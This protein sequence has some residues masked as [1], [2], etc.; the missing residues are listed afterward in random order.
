MEL[1]DIV[2]QLAATERMRITEAEGP[3]EC[4]RVAVA[5]SPP[6]AD[7]TRIGYE[8]EPPVAVAEGPVRRRSVVVFARTLGPAG[9]D[10]A[11]E[12]SG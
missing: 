6:V 3:V 8:P 9:E 4:S 10:A 11:L 2:D 1:P 5:S 7:T 12:R